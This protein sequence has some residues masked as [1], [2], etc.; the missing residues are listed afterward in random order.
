VF[1]AGERMFID[2]LTSELCSDRV[3]YAVIC[4]WLAMN[5]DLASLLAQRGCSLVGIN[6]TG[7]EEPAEEAAVKAVHDAGLPM[8]GYL[9]FGF[10][11]DTADVF[12]RAI[13]RIRQ[14]GFVSVA[15]TLLTPFPGTPMTRRIVQEG[16]FR[17]ADPD[18]L[19][20]NHLLF[21]PRQMTVEQLKQGY[22]FVCNELKD[23]LGFHRA[24][25]AMADHEVA[26]GKGT[27]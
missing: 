2:R 3:R 22:D 24:V 27:A 12:E 11:E 9:M 20:Q 25:A 16:R 1:G 5:G 14:Y 4:D 21:V 19:D 6:L 13:K 15:I 26:A 18:L 7:R 8:W 23:L 17:S 10:E